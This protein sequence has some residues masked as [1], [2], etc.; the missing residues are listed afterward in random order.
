MISTGNDIIAIA[1][2]NA[3]RTKESRF[4]SK[5][6]SREEKQLYSGEIAGAM[7]FEYFV[8][9]AW[10]IKESTYK[11]LKRGNKDLLFSPLKINISS[12]IC[13]AKLLIGA[14]GAEPRQADSIDK[15]GAVITKVHSGSCML[16]CRSI[17]YDE[18]IY[19]VAAGPEGFDAVSWGIMSIASDLASDQSAAVRSFAAARLKSLFPDTGLSIEKDF[20]GVPGVVCN[21]EH[22][23]LPLSFT[24]HHNFVAYSFLRPL[25]NI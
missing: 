18:L 16:E 9:L 11:Y 3:G 17:L 12:F 22:W 6:I 15:S 2:I 24:H 8:W 7:P 1:S 5:I 19:S 25:P 13:P 20:Y 10:S 23:R 14:L 21:G 4:Y